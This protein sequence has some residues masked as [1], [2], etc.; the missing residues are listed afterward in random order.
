MPVPMDEHV[1]YQ[2]RLITVTDNAVYSGHNVILLRDLQIATVVPRKVNGTVPL[3]MLLLFGLGWHHGG[4][5][6][7]AGVLLV[8]VAFIQYLR[9]IHGS[10]E[11]QV[12]TPTGPVTCL[13]GQKRPYLEEV[14]GRILLASAQA[15]ANAQGTT[16]LVFSP[17]T[18]HG[19]V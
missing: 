19:A 14:C 11:L 9:R 5:E 18:H 16:R 7:C 3:V 8:T 6:G 15:K 1:I 10:A 2:D 4:V 17:A 12:L 13:S